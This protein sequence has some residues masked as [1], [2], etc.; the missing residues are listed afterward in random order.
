MKTLGFT[1]ILPNQNK[2]LGLFQ[3][4]TLGEKFNL[5]SKEI[6]GVECLFKGRPHN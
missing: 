6:L 2:R 3:E 1:N 5:A 4:R